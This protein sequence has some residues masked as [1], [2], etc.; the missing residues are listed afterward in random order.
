[1]LKARSVTAVDQRLTE[2]SAQLKV[3]VLPWLKLN[4]GVATRSYA[5]TFANQHWTNL[6]LGGEA[7]TA[8]LEGTMHA[9]LRAQVMPLVTVTGLSSPRLSIGGGTGI[10]WEHGRFAGTLTYDV[11]RY[12]FQAI[13]GFARTEQ[14]SSLAVELMVRSIWK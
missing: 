7:Q 3:A 6:L 14:V 1:Q 9:V 2:A 8:L 10:R 5:S 4:G 11:E 13:N 12:R